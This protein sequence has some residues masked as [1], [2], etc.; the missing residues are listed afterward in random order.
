MQF[1]CYSKC[2]TCKKARKYLDDNGIEY[3]Y[4]EIT[5]ENPTEEEIRQ[6]IKRGNREINKCFNTSGKLY[7]DMKLKDKLKEMTDDEKLKLLATDG[8]L[9]KRPVLVT[10]EKVLFGFKEEEYD[11][12]LK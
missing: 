4:R 7:R 8:M 2:S 6:W 11:E 9:V 10:E 5:E 3:E 1:I 12:L